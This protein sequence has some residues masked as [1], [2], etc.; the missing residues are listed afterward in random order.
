MNEIVL[1]KPKTFEDSKRI[2]NSVVEEKILHIDLTSTDKKISQRILDFISGAIYIKGATLLNPT[3]NVFLS[4]P[5]AVNCLW[6]DEEKE[7]SKSNTVDL[8]Y[9]E[10]EEIKPNF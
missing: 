1:I 8:R 7:Y 9:D 10:E 6:S 3:E 2:V 5:K 4:V